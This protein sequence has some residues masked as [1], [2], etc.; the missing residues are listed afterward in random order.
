MY[1]SSS[2]LITT[3]TQLQLFPPAT[4]SS[5][6]QE[7]RELFQH[8]GSTEELVARILAAAKALESLDEK[9]IR[10]MTA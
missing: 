7:T 4:R 6:D 2:A 9:P 5:L 8:E 1:L 3:M 10:Q